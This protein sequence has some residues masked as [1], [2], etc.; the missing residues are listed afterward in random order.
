MLPIGG[1]STLSDTLPSHVLSLSYGCNNID[2]YNRVYEPS[3]L[4]RVDITR[5]QELQDDVMISEFEVFDS[6]GIRLPDRSRWN[7]TAS[8]TFDFGTNAQSQIIIL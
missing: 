5:Y 2:C 4:I 7:V 3:K 1:A 8:S 6:E